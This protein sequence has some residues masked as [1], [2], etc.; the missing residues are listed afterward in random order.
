MEQYVPLGPPPLPER[1]R[2]DPNLTA[3]LQ[4]PISSINLYSG[5]WA[6]PPR[7]TWGTGPSLSKNSGVQ[8]R[9]IDEARSIVSVYTAIRHI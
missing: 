2:G 4:M 3:P 6:A 8:Y 7:E 5:P 9:A 1:G